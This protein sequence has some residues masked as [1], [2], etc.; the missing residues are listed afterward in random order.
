MCSWVVPKKPK[1]VLVKST[2]EKKCNRLNKGSYLYEEGK[3]KPRD[4][5]IRHLISLVFNFNLGKGLRM[6]FA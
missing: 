3:K 4:L 6:G 1:N 5:T 2:Y